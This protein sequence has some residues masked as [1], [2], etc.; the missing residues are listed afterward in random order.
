[1]ICVQADINNK[2]CYRVAAQLTIAGS[3]T[4]WVH[5]AITSASD[6]NSKV[7]SGPILFQNNSVIFAYNSCNILNM[8]LPSQWKVSNV[9]IFLE[10]NKLVSNN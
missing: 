4:Q 3:L 2:T 5:A 8:S 9:G 10:K 7:A 6:A 1:M